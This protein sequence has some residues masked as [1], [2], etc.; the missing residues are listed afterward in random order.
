MQK[1]ISMP[2]FFLNKEQTATIFQFFLVRLGHFQV[3]GF[4]HVQQTLTL[5][6]KNRET[7]KCRIDPVADPIKLFS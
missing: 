1:I 5:N 2:L 4:F 7:K 3:Y 6:S